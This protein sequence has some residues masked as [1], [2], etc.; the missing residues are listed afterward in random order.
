MSAEV[1]LY[2]KQGGGVSNILEDRNKIN[3]GLKSL[4]KWVEHN[5]MKIKRDKCK[6]LYVCVF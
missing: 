2:I 5:A 1:P 4:E 3:N 6:V